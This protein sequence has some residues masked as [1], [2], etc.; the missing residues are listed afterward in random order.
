ME[1]TG[2][3]IMNT[4]IYYALIMLLAYFDY[5]GIAGAL[6][7]LLLA[8]VT[9]FAILIAV[10]PFGGVFLEALVEMWIIRWWGGFVHLPTNTLTVTVVFWFSVA[11]GAVFCV[12]A[13]LIILARLRRLWRRLW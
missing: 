4:I 5:H 8:I 10:I 12:L 7:G 9:S 13:S 11:L 6:A 2:Y 3:G 1:K